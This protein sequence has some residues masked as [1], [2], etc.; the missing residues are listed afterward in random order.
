M[1]ACYYMGRG[2]TTLRGFGWLGGVSEAMSAPATPDPEVTWRTPVE[3]PTSQRGPKG[4]RLP[5]DNEWPQ[6][7]MN[8]FVLS[9]SSK[10]S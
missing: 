4:L 2:F 1:T 6:F 5:P 10:M 8:V 9:F 3:D 7:A